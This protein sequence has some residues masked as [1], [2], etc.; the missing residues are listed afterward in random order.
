ML[1]MQN[2]G[3]QAAAIAALQFPATGGDPFLNLRKPKPQV[4]NIITKATTTAQIIAQEV[5]CDYGP[6][7]IIG[8]QRCED[9]GIIQ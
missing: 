8:R 4:A 3:W 1:S 2:G 9:D 5:F 6:I 7:V